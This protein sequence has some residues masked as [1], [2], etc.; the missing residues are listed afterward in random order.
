ML[1]IR[2]SIHTSGV[3]DIMMDSA[4]NRLINRYD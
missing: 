4:N 3:V 1:D 2:L